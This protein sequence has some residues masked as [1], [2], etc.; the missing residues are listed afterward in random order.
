VKISQVDPEIF[1]I[2]EIFLKR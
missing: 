2:Q 1:C